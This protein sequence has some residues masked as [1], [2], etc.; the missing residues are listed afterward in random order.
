MTKPLTPA[1]PKLAEVA[2]RMI[3]NLC[4][5]NGIK[6][7]NITLVSFQG[8]MVNLTATT[9]LEIKPITQ[10]K[11]LPGR[12][13]AGETVAHRAGALQAID[14][15]IISAIN[16]GAYKRQMIDI[17]LKRPDKGLG[18]PDS[19]T[20][21]AD[22]LTKDYTWHEPCRT[23][24]GAAKSACPKCQGGAR[25]NC[26]QCLGRTM[27]PC[28][29]CRGSGTVTGQG[30]KLQP[31]SRC[32]GQRQMACPLC[33]RTGK[34]TCRQCHGNGFGACSSCSG[35][36][37][38]TYA[39]HVVPQI[40]THFDYDRAAAP[41]DI[42]HL[43]DSSANALLLKGHL[44]TT[45]RLAD[46]EPGVLAAEYDVTFPH[47][48][49]IFAL[50]RQQIK[51]TLFGYKSRLVNLPHFLDKMVTPGINVLE[52]AAAGKGSVAGKIRRAS[53]YRMIALALL[54]AGQNSVRKTVDTLLQKYPLG[55]SKATAEK[56]SKYADAAV[57][58][59]TRKPRYA[60]LAMG[61]ILVAGLYAFYYLGDGRALL[62]AYTSTS[63]M[64]M[65]MDVIIILLGGTLTTISIQLSAANALRL[66]LG[67][68][69]PAKARHTLIPK[70]R[71]SGWWGY[72]GGLALYLIMI[73]LT[74]HI[75]NAVTP[76]WYRLIRHSIFNL[77]L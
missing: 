8:Q 30:G 73:E 70:T 52:Q 31:C 4:K 47:G 72:A 2:L 60:G 17:V 29:M 68:L 24:G 44:K 10:E 12:Q 45:A 71:G 63:M 49:I 32:H 9:Y 61:L 14:Q 28:T 25:E 69:V 22:F 76:E 33:Q 75:P 13:S 34:V 15:M 18:L 42:L 20:F 51:G 38:F 77:F 1:D 41:P 57:A 62:S 16:N 11:T 19:T 40:I 64:D 23:C 55:L 21:S 65:V 5:G 67:H 53:K 74:L 56:L 7:D 36:G 48:E 37:Y 26:P 3:Q 46:S 59:I 54:T 6:S 27:I 58:N 66:A 35:S 39:L 50:G 43:L